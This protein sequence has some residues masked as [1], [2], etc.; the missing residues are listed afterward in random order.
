[1]ARTVRPNE[2]GRSAFSHSREERAMQDGLN[3]RKVAVLVADGITRAELSGIRETLERAGASLCVLS[4]SGEVVTAGENDAKVPIDRAVRGTSASE[5]DALIIPGAATLADAL[6]KDAESLRIV[7]EFMEADK[8][9]AALGAGVR[10]L[11]AADTLR[12]RTVTSDTEGADSVRNAGGDWV[13]KKVHA[14]QKLITGRGG[15]LETFLSKVT[16][17]FSTVLR[18]EKLD[19]VVQQSFPASDPAPGP[20]A[21]G[22]PRPHKSEARA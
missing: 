10:V 18:E 17:S 2:G 6:T 13:D 14:D 9:V 8:L 3:G 21:S 15:E 7:R 11:A 22:A 4:S 12:G 16:S 5:F 1:L 19:E 20:V